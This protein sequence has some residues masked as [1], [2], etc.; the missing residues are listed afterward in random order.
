[1]GALTRGAEGGG[2]GGVEN[3]ITSAVVAQG[4]Q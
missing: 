3:K 1:M 2:S 4:L